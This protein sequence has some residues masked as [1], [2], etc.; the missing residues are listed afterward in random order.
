[1]DVAPR[2]DNEPTSGGQPDSADSEAE[3]AQ[4]VRLMVA[5]ARHRARPPDGA[6]REDSKGVWA[7]GTAVTEAARVL[8]QARQ[9]AV[10]LDVALEETRRRA[11]DGLT[12]LLQVGIGIDVEGTA[13]TLRPPPALDR[14]AQRV[15]HLHAP[16]GVL[17]CRVD[18]LDDPL[19]AA[20]ISMLAVAGQWPSLATLVAAPHEGARGAPPTPTPVVATQAR[21]AFVDLATLTLRRALGEARDLVASA[22]RDLDAAVSE[23]RRRASRHD[24]LL[25]GAGPSDAAT[26]VERRQARRQL[27]QLRALPDITAIMVSGDT[28]RLSTVPIRIAHAGVVRD[29]GRFVIVID[30]APLAPEPLRL[31]NVSHPRRT[32]GRGVDHPH[33]ADA[34]PRLGA[35]H[36]AVARG[37][38][39]ADVVGITVTVLSFLRHYEPRVA[40]API[41]GWPV[42]PDPTPG[43][44]GGPDPPAH[45]PDGG[46]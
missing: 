5:W 21:R 20:S 18:G 2:A 4:F 11:E 6:L 45:G 19:M 35:L 7:A 15:V 8:A 25:S 42:A 31:Y 33:V 39:D 10:E 9:R 17:A 41:D 46:V 38:A 24:I 14:A 32:G 40:Y 16:D 36:E 29:I 23:L 22:R 28:V 1:M 3:G 12:T 43:P 34:L 13:V 26:E 37:V 30:S 44:S 27:D